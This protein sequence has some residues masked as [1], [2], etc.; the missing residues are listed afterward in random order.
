MEA[1]PYD[2]IWFTLT[3]GFVIAMNLVWY[4]AK[5]YIK[6][7]GFKVGFFSSHF[8]DFGSLRS[9]IRDGEAEDKFKAKVY[10]NLLLWGGLVFVALIVMTGRSFVVV[11]P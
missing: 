7:R 4:S 6:R 8:R 9:I 10:F 3:V 2:N 1:N 5:F 11:Q